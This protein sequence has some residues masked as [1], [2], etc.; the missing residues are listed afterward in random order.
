MNRWVGLLL[1]PLGIG[2]VSYS[3][4]GDGELGAAGNPDGT[5]QRST[6]LPPLKTALQ[7]VRDEY[8]LPA[9]SAGI[10]TREGLQERATVGVRKLGSEVAATDQDRWHLGSCTKAMTATLLGMLV[11]QRSV[12]WDTKL[13][14][15]FPELRDQMNADMRQITLEHLLT[16]RSGLPANGAWGE[17]GDDR[18]TTD[19]RVELL[20]RM[21]KKTLAHKPGSHFEYSNV[22]YALAGLMAERITGESWEALME[23][24]VFQPLKMTSA[25]FGPAG[26]LGAVE[27]PWGHSP[28]LG[29]LG[30]LQSG[31]FDNPA[32]LGPAGTVH[33]SLDA[34]GKFIAL[35]LDRNNTLISPE[36]WDRLHK[37]A[38]GGEYAMGWLV[39]ERE[40][41]QD[42]L[43]QG[44]ALN[45]AGSN[46][47]NYCVCWLSPQLGKAVFAVTNTGQ[48]NAAQALDRVCELFIHRLKLAETD[49]PARSPKG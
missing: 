30:P 25:G 10:V 28:T 48:A 42:E 21:T 38:N 5:P 19:Q 20:R 4:A 27:Q 41:A 36:V 24:R 29:G 13:S 37:P 7:E 15:V 44:L 31:Q 9:L 16:H 39:V 43:G 11:D 3:L 22:G 1:W 47:L 33:A 26:T 12:D 32:A 18:S 17:L 2:L 6:D 40:W 46:T 23:R 49:E 35:H 34:W 8:Q 14:D 45:H